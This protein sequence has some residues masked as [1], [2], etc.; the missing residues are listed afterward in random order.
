MDTNHSPAFSKMG[1]AN[2]DSHT[3]TDTLKELSD[4]ALVLR[5]R[6]SHCEA[7]AAELVTRY[8]DKLLFFANR[9]CAGDMHMAEDVVQEAFSKA[10]SN[11]HLF[12]VSRPLQSWLYQIVKNTASDYLRKKSRIREIPT[13]SFQSRT[14]EATPFEQLCI[15]RSKGPVQE[16]I[17]KELRERLAKLFSWPTAEGLEGSPLSAKEKGTL[18]FLNKRKNFQ[19]IA[20]LYFKGSTYESIAKALDIPLG[21][22]K[23]SIHMIRARFSESKKS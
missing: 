8:K 13:T 1:G 15:D 9:R 18:K 14:E 16:A 6:D 23:S 5:Y 2:P 17:D 19:E 4:A 11:I 22:V 3:P 10:F 7:A 21:T 12:D 20:L